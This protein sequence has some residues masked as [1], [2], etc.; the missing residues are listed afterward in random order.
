[1][2]VWSCVPFSFRVANSDVIK[3]KGAHL[4]QKLIKICALFELFARCCDFSLALTRRQTHFALMSLCSLQKTT[5]SQA[6]I[7]LT[8][9]NIVE[10]EII[11][12]AH[13][14]INNKTCA[15][16]EDSDQPAHP[17]S[18]IRVFADRTCLLQH[19]SNPKRDGR[20]PLPY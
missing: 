2:S 12:P 18:L 7:K 11:E 20:E 15:N 5:V 4:E 16:S 3:Y 9:V 10:I 8:R 13:D 17:R 6:T 1:M 19:P 14:K